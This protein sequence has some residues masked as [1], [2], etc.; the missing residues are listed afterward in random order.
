MERY[1]ERTDQR[2]T[3]ETLAQRT[4]LSKATLEAIGSRD[5]Y[6][7][8]LDTIERIC[9]ALDCGIGA[10]LELSSDE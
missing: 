6:N 7:P 8:T 10:L 4:G 2:V 9:R 3:Y 1:G 5:N